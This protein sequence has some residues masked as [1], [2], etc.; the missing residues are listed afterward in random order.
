[1]LSKLISF[2][3]VFKPKKSSCR[4]MTRKTNQSYIE[5]E[6]MIRPRSL[7]INNNDQNDDEGFSKYFANLKGLNVYERQI[8]CHRRNV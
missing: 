5:N 6:I 7:N 4:V 2:L 8:S 3:F 1:M